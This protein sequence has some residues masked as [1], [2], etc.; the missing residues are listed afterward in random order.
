MSLLS[1]IRKCRG[2]LWTAHVI[3]NPLIS[4]H[5]TDRLMF[6]FL[7]HVELELGTICVKTEKVVL[8]F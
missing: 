3:P 4:G 7:A 1:A 5:T 2:I 8:R 6:K